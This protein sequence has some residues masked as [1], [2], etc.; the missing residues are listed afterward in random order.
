MLI[1]QLLMIGLVGLKKAPLQAGLLVP[2]PFITIIFRLACDTHMLHPQPQSLLSM[3]MAQPWH[4]KALP[5]ERV[6]LL[7]VLILV[8]ASCQTSSIVHAGSASMP[9]CD[10]IGQHGRAAYG[11]KLGNV[12]RLTYGQTCSWLLRLKH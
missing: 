12:I 9:H 8:C 7:I 4:S 11:F 6:S 5:Y 3:Q 10:H 1:W 2:L